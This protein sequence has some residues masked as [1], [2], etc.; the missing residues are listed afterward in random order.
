MRYLNVFKKNCSLQYRERWEGY[1]F[2]IAGAIHMIDSN[3]NNLK[4]YIREKKRCRL[5]T[6][7][8]QV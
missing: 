3:E 2:Y 1:Q 7:Y 5:S 4:V 6:S 8:M